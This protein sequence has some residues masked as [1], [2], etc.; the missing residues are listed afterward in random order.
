MQ[1]SSGQKYDAFAPISSEKSGFEHGSLR[2]S[3]IASMDALTTAAASGMQARIESMDMLANNL[4][5]TSSN[6]FKADREFYTSY[7]S[8]ELAYQADPIVGESPLIQKKW[9]DF[10]QGSL[11]PT[12][13]QTDLALSGNGFF[14]VNGPNGTLYTRNGNFQ[15]SPT[16][17]LVTADGY[18][19]R[20]T[21]NQTLKTQSNDPITVSP[22][23]QV[24]QSGTTL[25]QLELANFQDPNRLTKFAATYFAPDD[26]A[27]G[28]DAPATAQVLQ[29]KTEA[30]NATPAEA[31][32]RMITLLRHFEMLQHA[33]KI[34]AD[35]NQQS[36][37][38]VAKVSA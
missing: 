17:E 3:V 27:N 23:G 35:M 32:A 37:Q 10:S 36:V 26:P 38:E 24:S 11:V 15:M 34:G 19:V 7:L 25:G 8:P 22:D 18:P 28:P 4:S 14:A 13:N 29:G 21:G 16:G 12:G 5:N 9:T 33:V 1:P 31:S 20:L 2:A 30:S 6:G